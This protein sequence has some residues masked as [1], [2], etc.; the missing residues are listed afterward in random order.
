MNAVI[1]YLSRVRPARWPHRQSS[2]SRVPCRESASR[3]H[4]HMWKRSSSWHAG[5]RAATRT[6]SPR[7]PGSGWWF[8]WGPPSLRL[9]VVTND[10]SPADALNSTNSRQEEPPLYSYPHTFVGY[11]AITAPRLH[12]HAHFDMLRQWQRRTSRGNCGLRIAG[13]ETRGEAR[14][15]SA[16]LRVTWT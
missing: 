9:S 3:V 4:S 7:A 11:A 6:S 10:I 12:C 13:H 2:P 15:R 16:V 8:A 1:D 5:D 14:E